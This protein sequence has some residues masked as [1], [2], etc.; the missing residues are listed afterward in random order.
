MQ[1]KPVV[2]GVSCFAKLTFE[3]LETLPFELLTLPPGSACV[4]RPPIII[5]NFLPRPSFWIR[6]VGHAQLQHA[7]PAARRIRHLSHLAPMEDEHI[8]GVR[9]LCIPRSLPKSVHEGI[10]NHRLLPCRRFTLRHL[11]QVLPQ[12]GGER[13]LEHQAP[14]EVEHCLCIVQIDEILS[15]I[16]RVSIMGVALRWVVEMGKRSHRGGV[17][18]SRTRRT[19]LLHLR[20]TDWSHT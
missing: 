1:I 14:A 15:D 18:C 12:L 3:P 19:W 11:R 10:A 6:C 2:Q 5:S 20:R 13:Q 8:V 17:L 9:R 16:E 4:V 7:P